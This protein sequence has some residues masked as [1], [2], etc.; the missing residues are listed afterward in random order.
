MA[1]TAKWLLAWFEASTVACWRQ[2]WPLIES[3]RVTDVIG[4]GLRNRSTSFLNQHDKKHRWRMAAGSSVARLRL[5]SSA[6]S[7]ALKGQHGIDAIL[8]QLKRHAPTACL[9]GSLD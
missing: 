4:T 2:P 9:S 1:H 5:K 7:I 6:Q 3:G 8:N